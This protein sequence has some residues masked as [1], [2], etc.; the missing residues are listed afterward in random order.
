MV[1]KAKMACHKN[2]LLLPLS[3]FQFLFEQFS[4]WKFQLVFLKKFISLQLLFHCLP[5]YEKSTNLDHLRK[6]NMSCRRRE[7]T[8]LYKFYILLLCSWYLFVFL[9][10]SREDIPMSGL[11]MF[12]GAASLPHPSKVSLWYGLMFKRCSFLLYALIYSKEIHFIYNSD[13]SC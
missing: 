10:M 11:F 2:L 12:P 5:E 3:P 13:S 6:A 7:T 1:Q 4:L 8:Y 9:Y